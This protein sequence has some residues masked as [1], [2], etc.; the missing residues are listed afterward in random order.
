LRIGQELLSKIYP[1][2][3]RVKHHP[4]FIL[5]CGGKYDAGNTNS[6]SARD[7][8]LKYLPIQNSRLCNNIELAEDINDWWRDGTYSD[9]IT[10]E[11]DIAELAG[12]IVIFLESAG[13]IAELGAFSQV[14]SIQQ[15]LLVFVDTEHK[16]QESFISL[17]PIAFLKH[18]FP[19]SVR[20][21]KW[22]D[23]NSDKANALDTLLM[24]D[25]IDE[26]AED[27]HTSY[28]DKDHEAVF[29]PTNV[30]HQMLLVCDVLDLMLALTPSEIVDILS[31]FKANVSKDRVEQ[32]LFIL[33]KFGF[34][35]LVERGRRY[36]I[37]KSGKDFMRY[38]SRNPGVPIDRLRIKNDM[39][40]L[41][42][43]SPSEE[44]RLRAIR[45]V[46]RSMDGAI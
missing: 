41:Y 33:T 3:A 20:A 10:F 28:A 36:Y 19:D 17:G 35:E 4:G 22:I 39:R 34:I 24:E 29:V 21:Y 44:K 23:H 42:S 14:K 9:L 16:N 27:I 43:S 6:L 37:S 32:Y 15:K 18:F 12:L 25:C 2:E 30:R 38:K 13:A 8:L 46:Y 26:I 1:Y 40:D 5:L 7:Q 11:Q 31:Y 45:S